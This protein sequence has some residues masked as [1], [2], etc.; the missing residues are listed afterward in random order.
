LSGGEALVA[1]GGYAGM[2]SAL[3]AMFT[4][5][6]LSFGNAVLA[7]AVG[8]FASGTLGAAIKGANL[9]QALEAGAIGGAIGGAM[10]GLFQAVSNPSSGASDGS[11]P[12]AGGANSSSADATLGGGSSAA[13]PS[14]AQAA[15][16]VGPSYSTDAA[17]NAL[18]FTVKMPTLIVY[19]S[20]EVGG[21]ISA[22]ISDIADFSGGSVAALN[23]DPIRGN[24]SQGVNSALGRQRFGN[25][26][27]T[28]HGYPDGTGD[29]EVMNLYSP[30]SPLI[31]SLAP[32]LT[33]GGNLWLQTCFGGSFI[34]DNPSYLSAISRAF[35]GAPVY[36]GTGLQNFIYTGLRSLEAT[37]DK[38]GNWIGDGRFLNYQ[39]FVPK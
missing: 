19:S 8:G 6:G 35:A 31:S 24:I 34:V 11:I 32:H 2:G 5:G 37:V 27:L 25:I 13:T 3:S 29:P 36:Y 22:D 33:N 10:G 39:E 26:V 17:T 21:D 9:G 23:I 30:N 16:D 38:S 20:R 7:G 18:V 15:I 12:A 14:P 1:W 28:R 4:A